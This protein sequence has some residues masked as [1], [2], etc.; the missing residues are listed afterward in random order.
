MVY[1]KLNLSACRT[2]LALNHIKGFGGQKVLRLSLTPLLRTNKLGGLSQSLS[3][4]L[5]LQEENIYQDLLE[6]RLIPQSTWDWA[7]QQLQ[8]HYELGAKILSFYHHDYPP[9]LRLIPNPPPLLFIL[10]DN[11]SLTK[12]SIAVVGT[13]K[14]SPKGI[15]R[16]ISCSQLITE[17]GFNVVSGLALGIDTFAHKIALNKKTPTFALLAHGL[18]S[19]YPSNN[20]KLSQQIINARGALVSESPLGTRVNA[21]RLIHRDRLQAGL[22][23]ATFI[24][25]SSPQ[26]GAMHAGRAA[27]AQGRPLW[28]PRSLRSQLAEFQQE[29]SS[30][31]K[32]SKKEVVWLGSE[33][34]F[35]EALQQAQNDFIQLKH[36]GSELWQSIQAAQQK[37]GDQQESLF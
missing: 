24:V 26:G 37:L 4:P 19:I 15:K 32:R 36:K 16:V 25:E 30:N 5:S 7:E 22:A 21:G 31:Y 23:T 1:S 8:G 18:D 34:Q 11:E 13:R 12:P 2:L 33:A 14:P 35:R 20:L 3:R 17:Y 27:L 6:G 29:N 9:L 10:G 28:L